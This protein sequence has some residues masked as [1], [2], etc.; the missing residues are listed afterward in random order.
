MKFDVEAVGLLHDVA[1][2]T[3]A[4]GRGEYAAGFFAHVGERRSALRPG[5]GKSQC[6]G[7]RRRIRKHVL[8]RGAVLHR[9]PICS[10]I[11]I[12]VE[13]ETHAAGDGMGSGP[14]SEGDYLI[15]GIDD[16]LT[17]G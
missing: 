11:G 17:P 15:G 14:A 10:L 16:A 5:G 9:E 4:G 2:E 12:E 1:R 3:D 7:L 13:A 8:K 6:A